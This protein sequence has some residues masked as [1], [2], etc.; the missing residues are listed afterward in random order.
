[1]PDNQKRSTAVRI[2]IVILI[3][4]ALII[5]AAVAYGAALLNGR[6]PVPQGALNIIASRADMPY[7]EKEMM[8]KALDVYE[9]IRTSEA[10]NDMKK[11]RK[12][13]M[14]GT[15]QE[16]AAEQ[17]IR[18]Y[19]LLNGEDME[20][21]RRVMEIEPEDFSQ[22]RSILEAGMEDYSRTGEFTLSDGDKEKLKALGEK[23]GLTEE[24]LESWSGSYE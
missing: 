5:T 11:L 17:L 9:I 16:E 7:E 18:S 1:M 24:N 10:G 20:E 12:M 22:G 8:N 21:I 23:Y 15:S 6:V 19:S 13:V 2:V 4:F 14:S 3:A